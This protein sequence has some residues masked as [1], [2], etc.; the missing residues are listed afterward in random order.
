MNKYTIVGL[1]ITGGFLS[2]LAW[3]GWCTGLILLIAFVPFFLI[4]N[5]LFE[6]SR[7]FRINSYFIY[8][9]PGFVIFSIM[10]IGWMRVA[11]LTGALCVILGLS[12]LMSSTLLLAHIVRIKA[13]NFPGFLSVVTFWLSYELVSLN[14]SLVSPWLNLGNGLAK[15]ILFIQW[16]EFTGTGGGSLW[17]LCSN[18]F[19]S[20]FIVNHLAGKK[21]SRILLIA[22]IG[23]VVVPAALSALRYYSI[24]PS[25]KNTAEVVIVQPNIDPY[26]EKFVIPFDEQLRRVIAMARSASTNKTAWIMT[27]ETTV[28][29]PAD[30]DYLNEN[31]YV[32]MIK[33]F[34]R[35][36][37]GA[38]VVAGLVSFKTY[39]DQSSAP[40]KSAR[41]SD[42]SGSYY[43]HF[44][45]AFRIDTGR[46]IEVY[47]KS[48]LVPGI[49]MQ[50]ARGPGRLIS[51]ILPYLGGTK[52][53][54]GSQEER[55]CFTHPALMTRIAPIICYESVFGSFV[56]GY[57]KKGAEALFIIT[58]DG[59]WKG[60]I[61]YRQHLNYA[62]LRA[63]ETRRPVA[64]AANTGIS[65]FIDLRGRITSES[66]W[67][68]PAIVKG[69]IMPETR[70]TAYVKYGDY[71]M[72][73]S[74]AISIILL[75]YAFILIRYKKN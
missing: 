63:I 47:H 75:L 28:D 74:A 4:E 72:W 5:W 18:L 52:W 16:Y 58:N 45:S 62:C 50:F 56:T 12:L 46:I 73:F 71:L 48:K 20:G 15:D 14:F 19:L 32:N 43:D 17:I 61:G 38:S 8:I 27:P 39:H 34:N 6:N 23:I 35:H 37:P 60:T 33:V 49:E 30:L 53:G 59:W 31:I 65:C 54:Y 68:S 13:G 3:S 26:T 51:R 7:K 67:W 66:E 9:L 41:R 40:T 21:R 55:I 24:T 57:V 25:G 11:S 69:N 64:R 22:W 70:I 29:D 42:S 36:Y 44:N 10:A 2:G 1:S